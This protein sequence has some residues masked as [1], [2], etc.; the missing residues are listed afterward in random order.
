MT[1]RAFVWITAFGLGLLTIA[2]AALSAFGPERIALNEAQL[3]ERVNHEL[4]RQFHR[5]TVE[6]ATITLADGRISLRVEARTT[7]LALAIVVFARGVPQYNAERGEIL[8]GGG[9]T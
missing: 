7:A 3:Q 4:P 9:A 2:G 8:C 5:L 6:R 1:K